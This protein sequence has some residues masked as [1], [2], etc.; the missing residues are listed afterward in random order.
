MKRILVLLGLILCITSSCTKIKGD[1]WTHIKFDKSELYFNADGGINMVTA[2]ATDWGSCTISNQDMSEYDRFYRKV[3]SNNEILTLEYIT[4][5]RKDNVFE[6]SVAPSKD[7]HKWILHLG[8]AYISG[9]VYI[10]QNCN[11]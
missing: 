9:D 10:Y 3:Y 6:I 1:K 4:V 11:K 2:D 5:K 8:G 7:T